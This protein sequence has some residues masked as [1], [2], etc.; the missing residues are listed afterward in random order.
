MT[1][2]DN[3]DPQLAAALASA[4]DFELQERLGERYRAA[5]LFGGSGQPEELDDLDD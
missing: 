5:Q 1:S 4:L 2:D 3:T